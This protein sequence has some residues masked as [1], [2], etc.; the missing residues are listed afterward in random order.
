MIGIL[1]DDVDTEEAEQY[2][3]FGDGGDGRRGK[4]FVVADENKFG[5]CSPDD[6]VMR[7]MHVIVH[8]RVGMLGSLD[9]FPLDIIDEN[10]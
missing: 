5:R 4:V 3:I 7:N 1:G 10:E 6:L 2:L 8:P 9:M